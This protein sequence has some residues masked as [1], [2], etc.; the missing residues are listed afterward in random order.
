[1]SETKIP[2]W[3]ASTCV[4][5][6]KLI[7]SG[8][9]RRCGI[10]G[11]YCSWNV[12][13][14]A[15]AKHIAAAEAHEKELREEIERLNKLLDYRVSDMTTCM[16]Q[17]GALKDENTSLRAEVERLKTEVCSECGSPCTD[18]DLVGNQIE[19]G[20]PKYWCGFCINRHLAEDEVK[21]LRTQLAEMQRP[22]SDEQGERSFT[23]WNG[24]IKGALRWRE[25]EPYEQ[26]RWKAAIGAA[27][28]AK[29]GE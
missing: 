24:W 14:P 26:N 19:L 12:L 17:S 3:P 21:K 10:D 22:V 18:K 7:P 5:C 25:L 11:E 23:V 20:F 16:R 9:V 13:P 15:L 1:M 29:G 6:G 8:T 28:A 4:K 27:R 2:D